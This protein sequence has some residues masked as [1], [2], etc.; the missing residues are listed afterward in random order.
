MNKKL[1][2]IIIVAFVFR[3]FLIPSAHHGDLNNN[4]SWGIQARENG[5]RGLYEKKEWKYSAPNQPPLYILTFASFTYFYEPL[6]SF[7]WKINYSLSVFPSKII[8]FW[9]TNGMDFLVKLPAIIADLGIGIL[10]F[11]YFKR[12]KRIKIAFLLTV[13]WLFHPLTWYNSAV[14]GQTDAI[15]NFFGIAAIFSLLGVFW[16]KRFRLETFAFLM[17]LSLLFKASLA[18]FLPII[19]VYVLLQKFSLA[20]WLRSIS[21]S[22][23]CVFFVSIWFHPEIDFSLW[24]VSLWQ[25]RILPGEIGYLTANAFNFWWLIDPGKTLD[26]TVFLGLAVRSWGLIIVSAA[27]SIVI[28]TLLQAKKKIKHANLFFALALVAVLVFLF[29]TRIHERYLY[30]FFPIGTI[31]L[32]F[33]PNFW[34]PYVLLSITYL[35]NMYH[36]FWIPDVYF[37]KNLYEQSYFANSLAIINILSFLY[38]FRKYAREK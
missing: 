35:A 29:M 15:V 8:W 23:L 7:F 17:T 32:G 20:A 22:A 38:L 9:E 6:S 12:K 24:F 18:L 10:I 2:F 4:I 28:K 1:F 13:L 21:I 33:I 27:M 37:F 34:I 26:S 31:L 11:T 25:N 3:L 14:W 36:L 5:L 16:K 19:F 30:P